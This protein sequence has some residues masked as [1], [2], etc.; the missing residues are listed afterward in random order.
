MLVE[1]TIHSVTA[2]AGTMFGFSPASRN[3]PWIRSSGQ[4]VLPQG[5]DVEVAEHGGVEG[6]AA[7]VRERGGVGGLA[8]C[9]WR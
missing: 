3:T 2:R 4:G 5:G 9:R 7:A 8:R 1:R 6:V